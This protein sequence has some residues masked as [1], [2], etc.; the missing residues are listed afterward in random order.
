MIRVHAPSNIAL[1]KYMGKSDTRA[2]LPA[3][4]SLSMTLNSLRTE[5]ELFPAETGGFSWSADAPK[6]DTR[7]IERFLAHARRTWDASASCLEELGLEAMTSAPSFAIRAANT[8]PKGAGIASSASSFAALTLAVAAAR[9]SSIDE[10]RAAW[11]REPRLRRALSRISRQ[12]SGSSCRS[13]EGPW[14]AWSETHGEPVDSSLPEMAD[15][16]VVVQSAPKLVSSS[17]AHRR[18]LASPLWDGRVARANARLDSLC[19][20]IGQGDL[21]SVARIAWEESWEMHSLFH[22]SQPPFT[23]WEPGTVEL[24]RWISPAVETEAEPP[25]VTLDAGANVHVLVRAERGS[26]WRQGRGAELV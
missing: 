23:Y 2:N 15:L 21:K 10:F 16:V 5:L 13:F 20:A 4:S 12:G 3:N 17:E 6:L 7:E 11:K 22:T 18:I 9:A 25:I 1:V 24:L 14:V 19:S 8:F 26:E